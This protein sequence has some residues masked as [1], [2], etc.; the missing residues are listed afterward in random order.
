MKRALLLLMLGSAACSFA[1]SDAA[2]PDAAPMEDASSDSATDDSDGDGVKNGDDNCPAAA[3]PDQEDGDDDKVGDAC[4]NCAAVANP[5]IMTMGLG[6]VQRDHDGDKRGDVCDLCPHLSSATDTDGDGD[7]I[8]AACDPDDAVRN[9]PADF[10][11]FYEAPKASE[12]I[13]PAGAG[14]LADWELAQT[15]DKRLWWKQKA[16][17]ASRRQL[18]RNLPNLREAYVDTVFR[19]HTIDPQTGSNTLRSAS[20]TYGFARRGSTDYYFNCGIRHDTSDTTNIAITAV[21]S[22]DNVIDSLVKPWAG[23][24]AERDIHVVGESGDPGGNNSRLDCDANSADNDLSI[25][26]GAVNL[27]PDGRVGLRTYGMTVSFDYLFIVD[28]AAVPGT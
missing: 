20:V 24:L 1:G 23:V 25:D 16:T 15:D 3:N 12:W 7:G 9:P 17:G 6:L 18:L 21:Y 27:S 14:A 19:I 28:K 5:P 22:N 4:D 2:G 8:G 11:G 26:P 10:N 13:I